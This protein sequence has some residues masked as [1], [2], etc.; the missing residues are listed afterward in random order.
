MLPPHELK[1]KTFTRAIRGY[2]TTEVDE[3]IEFLI[4][5][6]TE[7]YRENDELERKYRTALAELDKFRGDEEAIRT[8]LVNAKKAGAKIT[9][10][11]NNRSEIVLRSAKT[12]CDRILSEFHERIVQEK[13]TLTKLQEASRSFKAMLV[14]QY[15]EQIARIEELTDTPEGDDIPDDEY[16]RS[17]V[18]SIKTDV[19]RISEEMENEAAEELQA[20][21]AEE[22]PAPVIRAKDDG[23][24]ELPPELIGL[25][26][27]SA[28]EPENEPE[29][30]P[31]PADE[32]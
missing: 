22:I 32:N 26:P 29:A 7:L 28:E 1:N 14:S 27:L 12:N 11:A 6:Y 15:G 25:V 23:T 30:A 17:I 2:T 20:A 10:D 9:R 3:H 24:V 31:A 8:A 19:T 18:A 4:A 16:I 21:E 13:E 5:Q